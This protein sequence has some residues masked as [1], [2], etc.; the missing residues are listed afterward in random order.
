MKRSRRILLIT[1]IA[2]VAVLG[3]AGIAYAIT[4]GVPDGDNH[5]YVGL[6]LF[7]DEDNVPLWRCSSS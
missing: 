1:A 2:L 7:Y 4:N 3:V 5:P 6:V